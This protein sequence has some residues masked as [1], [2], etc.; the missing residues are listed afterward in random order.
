[1]GRRIALPLVVVAAVALVLAWWA[2]L[3][4]GPG[5]FDGNPRTATAPAAPLEASSSLEPVANP[6][7]T[8]TPVPGTA[9]PT[10]AAPS[11][12]PAE[13]S[14]QAVIPADSDSEPDT[15]TAKPSFDIVRVEPDGSAVI[16]GRGR[17][18]ATIV[19]RNGEAA[20]TE[21]RSDANG[22]FVLDF[23]LP[24]GEH[25]LR[26]AE[27]GVPG[28]V[29]SD[30]AAIVSVP[31]RGRPEDLLVM[32]QRPGE[33]SRILVKPRPSEPAMAAL[34]PTSPPDAAGSPAAVPSTPEQAPATP[35]ADAAAVSAPTTQAR[36]SPPSASGKLT[37]EAVE[38]ERGRLFVAGAADPRS[39]IRIYLDGRLVTETRGGEGDRFIGSALADV[40][41]GDHVIRADEIGSDGTVIARA[42]VPFNRPDTGAMAAV[43]ADE[44]SA[45]PALDGAVI[46]AAPGAADI[47]PA[48][49]DTATEAASSRP[50]SLQTRLQPVEARVIIR[51]GD[52]LWRISRGTYGRGN[53]YSEIYLANGDQI[54]DPNRIYPGQVF[55]LPEDKEKAAPKG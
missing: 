33:P 51:R 2:G 5:A 17:P 16:A 32:M 22:D 43:A 37:V 39:T 13:P 48:T 45:I 49:A 7:A 35:S 24:V 23:A 11:F 36:V 40:A 42:E 34:A 1:M 27:A 19:L 28:E 44:P 50:T 25:R 18:N 52:S 31:P 10:A 15:A 26:L 54:R 6:P 38:I 4:S 55:R 21:T 3:M 53:R 46:T 8:A 30:D 47:T 9:A 12:A 14:D 41:V 20:L 29:A